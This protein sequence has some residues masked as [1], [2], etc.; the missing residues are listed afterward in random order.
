MEGSVWLVRIRARK[1]LRFV[2]SGVAYE[3]EFS[4]LYFPSQILRCNIA[5]KLNLIH[6][7]FLFYYIILKRKCPSINK[8]HFGRICKV[9]A[10]GT[11]D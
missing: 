5:I 4:L 11:V 2:G 7:T 9:L 8:T 3:R 10:G 1:L 6:Y